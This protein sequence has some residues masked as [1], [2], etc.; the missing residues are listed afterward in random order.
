MNIILN[1]QFFWG[2]SQRWLFFINLVYKKV[3]N[4]F[5]STKYRLPNINQAPSL[6]IHDLLQLKKCYNEKDFRTSCHFVLRVIFLEI[7]WSFLRKRSLRSLHELS[8]SFTPVMWTRHFT[9]L[10]IWHS[11]RKYLLK[12]SNYNKHL[13]NTSK[14]FHYYSFSI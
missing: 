4:S 13:L 1:K 9:W 3:E 6:L 14:S 11:P 12:T 5:Y 7:R 2:N 10:P 8:G